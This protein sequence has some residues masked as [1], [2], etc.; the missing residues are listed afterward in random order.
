MKYDFDQEIRRT[1]THSVKWQIYWRGDKREL[2]EGTDPDLGDDRTLPMWVADMDFPVAKPILDAMR[3]RIDHPIFGYVVRTPDY[4]E[5]VTSWMERRHGWKV[6]PDWIVNTPGVV[7]ALNLLVRALSAPGDKILIQRPVYYPFTY[8]I[9]NNGREVVSNSLVMENGVYRM[10]FAD[11]E[12]KAADPKTKLLVLCS[13]H[14]PVGRVWTEEELRRL[15]EICNKHGVIVIADEIH[16]DLMLNGSTFVPYGKL[17]SEFMDNSVVCTAPSKTFN[18]AGLHTSNMIV[19][20]EAHRKAL[21]KEI[22]ASGVGGMNTF[23]LEATKAAYNEGEE[24]LAQVLDYLSGNANYLESFVAERIPEIKVIHPEGTYLVWLD[25]RGLGLDK[26]E[27]EALMHEEVKVL[28]DEG[29]V[30]GSEGEGFE[31]I[32]IACP[33]SIL[34]EALERIERAVAKRRK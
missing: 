13:P 16:G 11:L 27:L 24:W 12:A 26:L 21:V 15:G 25:C 8:A 7:P 32:N 23:G 1:G 33:R 6:T 20:N 29:Y 9:E 10:D 14:N 28:F 17:G 2:W 3:K 31:R 19:S 30:F 34:T 18:L 5:A 4:N 22:A